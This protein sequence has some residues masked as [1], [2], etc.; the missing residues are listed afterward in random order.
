ML[1]V[2]H[3]DGSIIATG[4]WRCDDEYRRLHEKPDVRN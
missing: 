3:V 2:S 4:F 1:S